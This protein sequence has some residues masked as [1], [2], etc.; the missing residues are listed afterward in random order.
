MEHLSKNDFFLIFKGIFNADGNF[1]DY[2]LTKTSE[3]FQRISK[4]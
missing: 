3:N 4:M 2:V 1:E